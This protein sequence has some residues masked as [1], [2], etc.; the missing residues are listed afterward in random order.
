MAAITN[1]LPKGPCVRCG[2]LTTNIE[3]GWAHAWVPGFFRCDQG[4]TDPN[5]AHL[6]PQVFTHLNQQPAPAEPQPTTLEPSVPAQAA[7]PAPTPAPQAP[8]RLQQQGPAADATF[9][10][11]PLAVLDVTDDGQ[12][13]GHLVDGRTI[14]CPARG[15]PTL[16]KWALDAGLG[17]RRLHKWG[18]DADPLVILMAGAT[19]KMGLPADLEDRDG[20]RLEP[21]HK[22]IK[23][24]N[25]A[26]WTLTKRGFGPWPRIYKPVKDGRRIC[27]Q[28]AIPGAPST[29]PP[30]GTWT[31]T[32][33]PPTSP[34]PSA[35]TPNASSPRAARWPPAAWSSCSSCV[36]PPAR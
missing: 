26:G 30:A 22:V 19:K 14:D 3:D 24:L 13:L 27:V 31:T 34:A 36:L 11:G 2:H 35:P 8:A 10:N 7:A 25:K 6:N 9:P 23:A 5:L 4:Y 15:I 16:I 33:H 32:P 12:L 17:Q 28:L 29:P 21:G 1:D 18:N 20:L